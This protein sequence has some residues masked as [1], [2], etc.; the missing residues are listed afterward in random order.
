ML[1][2][3]IILGDSLQSMYV[4]A[5][6]VDFWSLWVMFPLIFALLNKGRAFHYDRIW[7]RYFFLYFNVLD[8]L[9]ITLHFS[10]VYV[11][12]ICLAF[13]IDVPSQLSEAHEQ[14][15]PR[16][17]KNAI[18]AT[19][20]ICKSVAMNMWWI[21]KHQQLLLEVSKSIGSVI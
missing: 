9:K 1:P 4:T 10:P 20:L 2:D 5:L 15:K 19:Q 13:L 7:W 16:D 21:S 3:G 11:N 17:L 14:R 8:S 18:W 12:Q 6:F